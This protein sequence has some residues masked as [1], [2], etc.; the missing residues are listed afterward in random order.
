MSIYVYAVRTSE[1]HNLKL[2]DLILT[3]PKLLE[4]NHCIEVLNFLI[5]SAYV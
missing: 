2:R 5:V 1:R 4:V 3:K